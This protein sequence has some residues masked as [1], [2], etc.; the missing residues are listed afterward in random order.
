MRLAAAVAL[1]LSLAG[2]AAHAA[3]GP[4]AFVESIV[5]VR[6][7][8]E[9]APQPLVVRRDADG[10]LLLKAADL[11]ALRI[12]TPARGLLLVNGERFYRIG[13]EIGAQVAFDDATQTVSVT[14]PA[15]AF[16]A[17]RARGSAPQSTRP[18]AR[19][20]GGFLNYEVSV[21]QASSRHTA[22]ALLEAGAFSGL[23]V[24]TT[25]AV[26]RDQSSGRSAVRLD[27][28]F[29]RDFPDQAATLRVG[30]AITSTGAWGQAV[31]FGGV[32]FGTNFATQPTLITTPLL[33]A[34]GEAVVPST[35]DVFINGQHVANQSV[36][37]GP[38]SIEN[39]PAVS[40]TGQMQVVVTDAL[41]RQQVIAQPYYSGPALLRAGLQEYSA[42]VGAIRRDYGDAS[43]N[44]G[45]A[46]AAGTYRRG[47]TN[48]LTAEVHAEAQV[49]GPAAAGVNAAW[50]AGTIGVLSATAAV[51]G[52]TNGSG[53]RAGLGFD[54]SGRYVSVFA[55]SEYASESF[56]QLGTREATQ[57][58]RQRT[59]AG[60]GFDLQGHG[61]LQIAYG[62]QSYWS[63]PQVQ[64]FGLGYSLTLGAYGFLNFFASRTLAEDD[65]TNLLLSWTMPFGDRRTVS[66]GVSYGP[67]LDGD[68]ETKAV[69]NF[70]QSLPAGAGYGYNVTAS[71][72]E[73]YQLAYAL[74]G[75][76]GRVALE[77]A[78]R[79]TQDGWRMDATGGLAITSAG[80]MPTRW[81]DKSFAVVQVDDYPG[82][83]VYLE[84]QPIGRTDSQGRVLLDNLR[85]YDAN[86]IS[87]DPVQ[88]PMDA[89]LASA[90]VEVVPA[91]RSGS[92]VQFPVRRSR[93][94][95]LRL[96]LPGGQPV[97]AGAQVALGGQTYPVALDG[98]LY[99][100]DTG[101]SRAAT[102]EWQ[103][104]R[105]EF[106][107]DRPQTGDP[108]PDLGAVPCQPV[109]P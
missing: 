57:R 90:A 73:D 63:A 19:G 94:A 104:Q 15:S 25:S 103:G 38:F 51:G 10:T 18:T 93:A 83:T 21:Q 44:Y 29:T 45:S 64:N 98:L 74:Q 81:L 75:S 30:D 102:A 43:A 37:P 41:G 92:V 26:A 108:V 9:A 59:F 78:R 69:A 12:K 82:M 3:G 53:W 88:L 87:I 39:V 79:E 80:V 106:A 23:G 76:A 109:H 7:N 17:T 89:S 20:V 97:P 91:Y 67:G 71:T 68:E 99:L 65:A 96:R 1:A 52:D 84:N 95:T 101:S 61:N 34:S 58:M 49:D 8:D 35:V 13:P 31:R 16:V 54:R 60:L 11:Q 77:Y 47:V 72:A 46:V 85:P 62:L 22:G 28:T 56:A 86:R 14:L 48:T 2:P 32:Q 50:Q 6:V 24:V 42:E 105:C 33:A 55:R 5:E 36:P 100:A 27:S 4:D 70:Q 66:T 40:G 107:I